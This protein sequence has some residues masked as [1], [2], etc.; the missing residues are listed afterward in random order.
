M[1]KETDLTNIKCDKCQNPITYEY[2]S[3]QGGT[4]TIGRQHT[5][6]YAVKCSQ[7][8][9][10]YTDWMQFNV[11]LFPGFPDPHKCPCMKLCTYCGY[12]ESSDKC[13]GIYR[14]KNRYL[15]IDENGFDDDVY[16][17]C[18]KCGKWDRMCK[19]DCVKPEPVVKPEAK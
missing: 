13:C 10:G 9:K 18:L 5:S 1:Y 3:F 11:S 15:G 7:C 8:I 2:V 17:M 4:C 16:R 12:N 19:G 14:N 6:S